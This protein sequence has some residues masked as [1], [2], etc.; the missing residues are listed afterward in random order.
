ME[1][2]RQHIQNAM[3]VKQFTYQ[4]DMAVEAKKIDES[5][6][7]EI[8]VSNQSRSPSVELFKSEN[9]ET[10]HNDAQSENEQA[11]HGKDE[12]AAGTTSCC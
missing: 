5:K 11:K 1:H 9:I 10:E 8:L 4:K 6:M 12:S 7:R 3:G 2:V